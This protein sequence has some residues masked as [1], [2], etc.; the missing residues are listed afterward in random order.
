MG[1][2]PGAV[3]FSVAGLPTGATATFTPTSVTPNAAAA[4][5]TMAVTTTSRTALTPPI[6]DFFTPQQPLK[7]LP[8]ISLLVALSLAMQSLR[9]F[10]RHPTGKFGRVAA[11]LLLLGQLDTSRAAA[12]AD[13]QRTP[14]EPR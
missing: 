7:P 5:T 6:R 11:L 10:G 1:G 12:A 8:M 2:F 9:K 4:T 3:G 14:M 13:P